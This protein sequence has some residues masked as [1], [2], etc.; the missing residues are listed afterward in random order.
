MLII[1]DNRIPLQA[2]ENLLKHGEVVWLE[3]SNI[4]EESVSGHPD[5]FFCRS[6]KNLIV[7]PNLPEA[8]KK[9]LTKNE[10]RFV[11]GSRIVSTGY[12]AAAV[13]NAVITDKHLIHK[14]DITDKIILNDCE[15][16][17]QIHVMQG[18][19]RCSLLSLKDGHFITSDTGI[20][21]SLVAKGLKGLLVSPDD[22]I[23]PGHSHGFFGG[24]CGV[25]DDKIFMIG[26]LVFYSDAEKVKTF[27]SMLGYKVIE[28]YDG[29]LFDGGSILFL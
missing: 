26:N 16:L 20:S 2:K 1:A 28:L 24:V 3:T 5:I 17:Q 13:Y 9:I 4:T 23:L 18:F 8:Y 7:A 25:I 19:T 6:N 22:I 21:K 27:V 14:T 29:P 15:D 11:E 12:P 10:I